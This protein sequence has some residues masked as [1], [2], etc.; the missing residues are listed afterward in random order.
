MVLLYSRDAAAAPLRCLEGI[1]AD[2]RSGR[3]MPDNTRSGYF[4][5]VPVGEAGQ[6]QA[7]EELDTMSDPSDSEDSQDEEDAY[8]GHQATENAVDHVVGAWN[9]LAGL[10]DVGLDHTAELFRNKFTRYI[11]VVSDEAGNKFRCGRDINDKYV[12]MDT[13]PKFRSPQC[14]QCFRTRR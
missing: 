5:E 12:Q 7:L 3:F 8:V 2:I 1:L 10:E 14:S 11:H 6:S 4:V 13:K 9:E